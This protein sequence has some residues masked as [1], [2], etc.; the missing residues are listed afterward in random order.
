VFQASGITTNALF[1]HQV[2]IHNRN[3]ENA[4][5]GMSPSASWGGS[6]AAAVTAVLDTATSQDIVLSGQLASSGETITRESYL[7]EI[8]AGA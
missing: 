4:Q 3:A 5:V 2:E 6:G 7:I 1:R 8:A